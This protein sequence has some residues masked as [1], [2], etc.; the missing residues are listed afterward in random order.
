[1]EV[2][3]FLHDERV[4]LRPLEDDDAGRLA[5][6]V[7]DQAVLLYLGIPGR[8]TSDE[9]VQW[10]KS[11]RDSPR[12]V[13][14]GIVDS[15]DGRLVGTVGLHMINRTDSN[16][17][18]GILIGEKDRWSQGLG[19]AAGRLMSDYAFNTLNLHRLHLT[20]AAFNPRGVKSYER[21]GFQ[22]EG[23]LKEACFKQGS[24]HDVFAMG[25]LA[26]DFNE[27]NAGWRTSQARRYGLENSIL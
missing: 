7:N 24:Y 21:L 10:I 18:Y 6:W 13:V 8:L 20:V 26:R 17:M 15:S 12:D 19:T 23:T 9:E 5:G 11:M 25:L 22:L 16:A 2:K 1:M 14:L 27:A 4:A 3:G